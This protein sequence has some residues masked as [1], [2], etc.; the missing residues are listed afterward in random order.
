M[1]NQQLLRMIPNVTNIEWNEMKKKPTVV[2]MEI[3]C[4]AIWDGFKKKTFRYLRR[5]ETH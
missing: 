2:L 5:R 4:V 1:L 3:V